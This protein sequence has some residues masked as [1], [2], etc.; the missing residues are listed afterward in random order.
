[1][2]AAVDSESAVVPALGPL[3]EIRSQT[4]DAVAATYAGGDIAQILTEAATASNTLIET[5]NARN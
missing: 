1:M 3:R 5:Y 4:A 2:L